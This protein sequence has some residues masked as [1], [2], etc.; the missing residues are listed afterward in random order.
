MD[1]THVRMEEN[2]MATVGKTIR[3]SVTAALLLA[4]T[5]TMTRGQVG[6]EAGAEFGPAGDW[7][8]HI[9]GKMVCTQC[10][11][12]DVQKLQPNNHQLYE[13][14]YPQ[15]QEPMPTSQYQ[16][17]SQYHPYIENEEQLTDRQAQGVLEVSGVSNPWWWNHL[18]GPR[19]QIRG[20]QSLV[21]KLTAEENVMKEVELSGVLNPYQILELQAVTI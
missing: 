12:A 21:Q 5:T 2:S 10:R 20:E 16:P 11:L 13:L 18:P 14:T 8:I 1:F 17:Y 6:P 3:S 15:A 19:L 9:K 7:A 4:G